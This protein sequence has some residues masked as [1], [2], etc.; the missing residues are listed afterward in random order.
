[1]QSCV[2]PPARAIEVGIVVV[3]DLSDLMHCLVCYCC[4]IRWSESARI[5]SY[6][7]DMAKP[8]TCRTCEVGRIGCKI[9][10]LLPSIGSDKLHYFEK[11]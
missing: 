7:E 8:E 6:P 3:L 10:V 5:S 9:M 11:Y 1:M 4:L 2:A